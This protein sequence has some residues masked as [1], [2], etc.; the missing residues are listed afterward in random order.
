MSR[1]WRTLK[2]ALGRLAGTPLATLVTV[3]VIGIALSLPAGLYLLLDHLGQ[4]SNG[5]EVQPQISLFLRLDAG[6]DDQQQ[7]EKQLKNHA[8]IKTFRFVGRD[9]ALKELSAGNGLGDL[10]AGLP[11]NPLPDAFVITTR[12]NDADQ[13]DKLRLEVS[14]WPGVESAVLDSAWAKRL[15]AMLDLGRQL[16]FM[17][18]A[19]LAF[20]LI[21]GMGNIIR[22]QI[23]TRQD[24][25]EISKLIGAT[26]RFIRLPFLYHGTLQGL[27]GG[28]AAWIIIAVS[29]QILNLSVS[30]LTSLYGS[31]FQLEGLALGDAAALLGFSA[32]LGWI[33]SYLAVSHFLRH[34]RISHH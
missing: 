5:L 11:N 16:T 22:L 4:A 34:F 33:G 2:D 20:G 6:K 19:L 21:A 30:R 23:L 27:L 13:L 18:S 24:E 32:I 8:A 17:L 31:G 26:D 25:I 12:E 14:Q 29:A 1:H 7:V 15:S 9:Q 3:S 10:A 28:L